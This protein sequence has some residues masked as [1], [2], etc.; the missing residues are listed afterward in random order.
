MIWLAMGIIVICM[1]IGVLISREFDE[2]ICWIPVGIAEIIALIMI[3]NLGNL[4]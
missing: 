2:P 1:S 3:A 4:G